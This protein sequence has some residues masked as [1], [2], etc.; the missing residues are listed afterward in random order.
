MA[1]LGHN[2]WGNDN[3]KYAISHVSRV[4]KKIYKHNKE[5]MKIE[6]ESYNDVLYRGIIIMEG[7]SHNVVTPV[8]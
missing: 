6:F 5:I 2:E 4:K 8:P 7:G 1:S 3:K